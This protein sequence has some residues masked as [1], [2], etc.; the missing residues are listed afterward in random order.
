MTRNEAT[1][2]VALGL[3]ITGA[4]YPHKDA[5]KAAGCAWDAA[6]K[7]WYAPS[8]EVRQQ[9]QDLVGSTLYNSPPPADTTGDV[10]AEVLAARYGRVAV[11]EAKIREWNVY[12]LA[13]GDNGE[14]NGSIHKIKGVRYVQVARTARRYYS[15]DMLEDFDLFNAEP[16]GAYQ[17]TGVAVEPT[18]EETAKDQV[19]GEAK[20]AREAAPKMWEAVVAHID[21][22]VT[23]RPAWVSAATLV[24]TW[25]KPAMIHTGSYPEIHV[26]ETEVYYYVPGYFACD[27]DYPTIQRVASLTDELREQLTA[28]IAACRTHGFLREAK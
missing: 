27:W 1:E 3:R 4:T 14:A 16:G 25:G 11:V 19:A 28:A 5:I 12:G 6:T 23:E 24:A 9:M 7:S 2:M 22:K 26:G 21:Q 8:E 17:W 20:A 13:K 18:A 15:R 10:S